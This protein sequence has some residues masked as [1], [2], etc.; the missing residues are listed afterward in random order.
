MQ[1]GGRRQVI[2]YQTQGVSAIGEDI[3]RHYQQGNVPIPNHNNNGVA[4]A[5]TIDSNSI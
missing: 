4:N 1:E 3:S 5:K 2:L